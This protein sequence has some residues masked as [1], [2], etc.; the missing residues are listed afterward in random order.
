MDLENHARVIWIVLGSLSGLGIIAAFI[1]TWA[2][3]SKSGKEVIDLPVKVYF[4]YLSITPHTF[5]L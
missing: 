2:W 5:S 4:F 3:Y 1:R